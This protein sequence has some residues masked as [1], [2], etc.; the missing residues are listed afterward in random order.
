MSKLIFFGLFIFNAV[1]L[2]A[3]DSRG[4]SVYEKLTIVPGT[5]QSEKDFMKKFRE[6]KNLYLSDEKGF[7][8]KL[9]STFPK[10]AEKSIEV[11]NQVVRQ[12]FLFRYDWDMEKTNVPF[13]FR[14]QIDWTAIPFGDPEWCFMLNRHRYWIDL[15]RAYLLTGKEIYAQTWVKQVTDWIQRNPVG[16]PKLKTLSWRRI[17]AGIRCENWIKS[18]EYFKKSPSLSVEFMELF[19]NSLYGHAEYINSSFSD[20]SKT[21]NWGVLEYQGLFNVAVFMP[22]FKNA[23][24][25]KAN[26][27]HRLAVCAQLQVLPDGTQ[28][29]QSPMYHNEVFHCLLNVCYLSRKFQI[30][31]PD[32]ILIKTKA[33][34]RVNIQWQKPDFHQPLTGDSDDTDLRGLLSTAAAVFDDTLLKSGAFPEMDYDNHY[35]FDSNEQMR[36]KMMKAAHPD[37]LSV[38]LPN[39]GQMIMRNSWSGSAYYSC[40][41]LKKSGS[42]HAH[43]DILNFSLFAFGRDYLVDGGRYTYVDSKTR[44]DLK[45]SSG[46]NVLTVDGLT[47]SIYKDSWSNSYNAVSQGIFTKIS[48]EYDYAEAEN[49]AFK[50]LDDPVYMKRRVVYIKPGLWLLF[51]S[52][53]ANKSH[54]YTINFNFADNKVVIDNDKAITTGDGSR[55]AVIALKKTDITQHKGYWS[56]EY[57]LLKENA[58]VKF[59]RSSAGFDSFITAICFPGQGSFSFSRIPVSDRNDSI[60][61]DKTV[62]A[63]KFQYDRREFILMVVHAWD[64]AANPFYKIGSELVNGEVVLLEKQNSGYQ[65]S[66]IKD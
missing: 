64:A 15:G 39:S 25:W 8:E 17:E 26:A 28:W 52:F 5:K 58:G 20:F 35:I 22:E 9:K 45:S 43:D 40:I 2:T 50:R 4:S 65:K 55:L 51:D 11:A 46:H 37:F 10:E 36:Y 19:L 24:Q 60:L 12:Y 27:V 38:F 63:I 23:A 29:E 32:T 33:L 53:A 62:E 3:A 49:T 54:T 31:L 59:S 14:N 56:P 21:S 47:N 57:N 18:F 41:N 61:D 16:D 48:R 30:D 7:T 13:Q 42:G 44:D 1:I 6:K 34:A 66:V